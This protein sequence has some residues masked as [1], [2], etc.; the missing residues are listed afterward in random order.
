MSLSEETTTWLTSNSIAVPGSPPWAFPIQEGNGVRRR[1]AT[2]AASASSAI[3]RKDI[4]CI[5]YVAGAISSDDGPTVNRD[6]VN[7]VLPNGQTL[8][9]NILTDADELIVGVLIYSASEMT[10]PDISDYPAFLN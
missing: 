2:E 10:G 4:L 3:R 1:S 6:A 7:V 8:K 9:A 5:E